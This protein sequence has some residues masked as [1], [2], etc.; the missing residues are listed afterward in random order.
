MQYNNFDFKLHEKVLKIMEYIESVSGPNLED[1]DEIMRCLFFTTIR[2]R[3][4][5]DDDFYDLINLFFPSANG[6]E[7]EETLPY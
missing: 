3:M 2:A 7:F 4:E 6:E 5:N 1:F